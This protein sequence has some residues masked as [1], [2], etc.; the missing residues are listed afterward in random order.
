MDAGHT[1]QPP[2]TWTV[3]AMHHPA[4]SAGHRGSDLAVRRAWR[5]LFADAGVPLVL[6]GHEHDYRRSTPQDGVT[7]SATL[8]HLDLPVH[9]DRIAGRAIDQAGNLGTASP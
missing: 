1:P 3:A 5:P 9:R 7:S 2:V 8:H 4:Y 6:A